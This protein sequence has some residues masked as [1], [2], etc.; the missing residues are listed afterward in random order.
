MIIPKLSRRQKQSKEPLPVEQQP[1]AIPVFRAV[2]SREANQESTGGAATGLVGPLDEQ[3]FNGTTFYVMNSS[4]GLF[5]V[6]YGE[7][8]DWEDANESIIRYN[9][10]DPNA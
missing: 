8:T 2:G 3:T 4:E 1:E 7:Y 5:A 10:R 6:R 9:H